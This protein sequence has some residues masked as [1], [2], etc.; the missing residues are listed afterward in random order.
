MLKN[1]VVF[2]SILLLLL[3]CSHKSRDNEVITDLTRKKAL[4]DIEEA[5]KKIRENKEAGQSKASDFNTFKKEILSLNNQEPLSIAFAENLVKGCLPVIDTPYRDSVFLYFNN[6]FYSVANTF[7]DSMFNKYPLVFEILAKDKSGNSPEVNSFKNYLSLFGMEL[8]MSEGIYYTDVK[9]AYFYNIFKGQ[10]SPAL[11]TYLKI[12]TT[13]LKEGFSDD[14]AMQISFEK[15]YRRVKNWEA[16]IDKYPGF[17]LINYAYYYYN[18]Y[19]ATLMT[20]MDNTPAFDPETKSLRPELKL[21]YEEIIKD[22]AKSKTK[23]MIVSYY[24]FLKK[25]NFTDP[26]DL[27]KF[28]RRKGLYSMLGVQPHLR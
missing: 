3:S 12:R 28:M 10:V 4:P 26:D 5:Q 27:E 16:F 8:L 25:K 6:I 19:L 2:I 21:I 14:A 22:T 11:E 13:E 18:S 9:P 17:V 24:G 20:G 15:L 1:T 7:S 23:E